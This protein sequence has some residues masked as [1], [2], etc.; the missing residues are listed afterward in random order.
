[1]NPDLQRNAEEI[2]ERVRVVAERADRDPSQ[3]TV[4]AV[5]KTFDRELMD[6]AYELGFRVFG[7]SR[8]QEIRQKADPPF[9]DGM[10]LHMIGPLQTNKIRQILPHIDVLQTVD[11]PRLVNALA[12]ELAKR[13]ATL[14][15]MLQVNVSGEVQKSGVAPENA[16]ALLQNVLD[17]DG[18]IPVGLMTM[19]PYD[20]DEATIRGVFIGLRE[21]R[22]QLQQ[23]H[24]IELP[25]L[26]M[27]MSD[28]FEIAIAEGATHIRIGRSLF[29]ARPE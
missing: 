23:V 15:V 1:M 18:L 4:V 25:A 24:G 8:A 27:G 11:R 7:E 2:L 19:A 29:G 28:D 20:A 21:L 3:I 9:P 13:E 17:A 14:K 16:S 10:E 12:K 26:S 6:Q 22:N 5:S